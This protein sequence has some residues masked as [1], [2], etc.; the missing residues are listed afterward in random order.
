MV[1]HRSEHDEL[2]FTCCVPATAISPNDSVVTRHDEV[3][4]FTDIEWH[5]GPNECPVIQR[6]DWLAGSIVDRV[7]TG[8]HVAFVVAT[9]GGRCGRSAAN[10]LSG[11]EV[12]DI[13]AGHPIPER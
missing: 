1:V 13:E 12:G 6:L 3:D 4:K 5:P 11:S 2:A 10:Q 7:D 8:D 9:Q